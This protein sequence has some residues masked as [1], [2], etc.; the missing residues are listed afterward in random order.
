MGW[1]QEELGLLFQWKIPST[2]NF[3][4]KRQSQK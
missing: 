4:R 1:L 3:T 2:A